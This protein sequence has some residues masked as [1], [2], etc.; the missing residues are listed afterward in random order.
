MQKNPRT[1]IIVSV[2]GL[3]MIIIIS[4]VSLNNLIAQNEVTN[5]IHT[6]FEAAR[7]NDY[8]LA[9]QMALSRDGDTQAPKDAQLSLYL[10]AEFFDTTKVEMM[11]FHFQIP[12]F[13]EG[14]ETQA[15]IKSYYD[16]DQTIESDIIL[17]KTSSGWKIRSITPKPETYQS[18]EE[19]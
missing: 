6:Y 11:N 13:V 16:S 14:S 8:E 1:L 12:P 9:A 10:S 15:Q 3:L 5:V 4:W 19:K 2:F 17:R 7:R 18:I